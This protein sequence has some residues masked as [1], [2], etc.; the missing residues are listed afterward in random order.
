MA[1]KCDDKIEPNI[2]Q[3]LICFHCNL[4]TEIALLSEFF[5]NFIKIKANIFSDTTQD[6]IYSE[7]VVFRICIY[8]LCSQ[9]VIAYNVRLT[10]QICSTI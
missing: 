4:Q 2:F 9:I 8:S 10:P 6:K 5:S 7:C 3:L 1:V